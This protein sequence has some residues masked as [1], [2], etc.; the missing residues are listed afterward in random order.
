MSS[1]VK[2]HHL[3]VFKA[4]TDR[5]KVIIT[6]LIVHKNK[7]EG[8]KSLVPLWRWDSG[9]QNTVA[10]AEG[11]WCVLG[12]TQALSQGAL[13]SMT[14]GLIS[15]EPLQRSIPGSQQ[16][17]QFRIG[18]KILHPAVSASRATLPSLLVRT[19][20][21]AAAS[22]GLGSCQWD[23]NGPGGCFSHL[24]RWANEAKSVSR[25]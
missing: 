13:H 3:S 6:N 15:A 8:R 11:L 2:L 16:T 10:L 24:I 17:E 1:K 19:F 5:M 21:N 12:S 25:D 18:F 9:Y 7:R 14:P 4:H 23:V 22:P 20:V